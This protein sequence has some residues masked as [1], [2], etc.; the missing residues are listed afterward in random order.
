[1]NFGRRQDEDDMIR[2]LLQRFEQGIECPLREHMNFVD[3][4]NLFGGRGR[5]QAGFVDDI[6]DIVDSRMGG[7]VNFDY[8]K[9]ASDRNGQ[10]LIAL[11]AGFSDRQIQILAVDRL[12]QKSGSGRLA[13]SARTG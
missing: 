4:I 2:R 9:G 3:D 6:A 12:S 11:V 13:G 5:R 7:G 1:M 10:A 8:I